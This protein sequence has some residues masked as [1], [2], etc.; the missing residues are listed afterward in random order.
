M[1]ALATDPDTEVDDPNCLLPPLRPERKR[2]CDIANA[3]SLV[4]CAMVET[5]FQAWFG[6]GGAAAARCGGLTLALERVGRAAGLASALL[7]RIRAG[8]VVTV[9]PAA[10][11]A[12]RPKETKATPKPAP[13]AG[14]R[15]PR[16]APDPATMIDRMTDAEAFARICRELTLAAKVLGLNDA[17]AE[18]AE[19]AREAAALLARPPSASQPPATRAAAEVERR[20]AERASSAAALAP[21]SV[22]DGA[23]MTPIPLDSG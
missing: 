13:A 6:L 23:G 8:I 9:R 2:L 10:R 7:L 16:G 18:V 14:I 11:P 3:L 21:E 5:I 4:A 20:K 22:A 17:I 12:A 1:T 19:M 15:L